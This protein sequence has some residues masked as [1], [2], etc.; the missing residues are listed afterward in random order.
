MLVVLA[1]KELVGHS[2]D[3]IA[4]HDVARSRERH[5]FVAFRHGMRLMQIEGEEFL[6][7]ADRTAGILGDERM[8]VYM[9]EEETL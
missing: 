3:V 2:G 4:D 1:Q 7:A 5:F 8:I 9:V 6:K